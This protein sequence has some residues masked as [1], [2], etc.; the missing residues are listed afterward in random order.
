MPDISVVVTNYNGKPL[1][2]KCIPATLEAVARAGCRSE[3]IL[4]DDC[5][6][7]DSVSFVKGAYPEVVAILPP[8]NLGF[9]EA[10]NFGV[11]KPRYTSNPKPATPWTSSKTQ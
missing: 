10:S 1:L 9:Q 5:S 11:K 2:E 8:H 6:N 3:V 7:D 4:V